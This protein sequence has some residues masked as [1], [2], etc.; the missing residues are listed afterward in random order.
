MR[1]PMG[2]DIPGLIAMAIHHFS[3][4][5]G[6]AFS[7]IDSEHGVWDATPTEPGWPIPESFTVSNEGIGALIIRRREYRRA[8]LLPLMFGGGQERGIRPGTQAVPLIVGLGLASALAV[9]RYRQWQESCVAN[10]LEILKALL[11]MNPVI[12]GDQGRV[13]PSILNVSI[14]GLDSEAVMVATKKT[15]A[16]ANGAACTSSE[17]GYSHVLQAMGFE[18][19]QTRTSLRLSWNLERISS[20]IGSQ[21][22]ESLNSLVSG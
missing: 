18:D 7:F 21:L 3:R 11:P 15:L 12:H 1:P 14:P 9:N 5:G 4:N 2:V 19:E 17:Y 16:I 22:A 6:E 8:P 10:R 13:L 20:R